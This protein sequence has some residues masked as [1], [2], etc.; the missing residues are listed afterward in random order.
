MCTYNKVKVFAGGNKKYLNKSGTFEPYIW[1][2]KI[3]QCDIP[4]EQILKAK[5][6]DI[7]GGLLSLIY[8]G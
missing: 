5:K 6:Y 1:G 2:L 3:F 8:I 4:D 7:F